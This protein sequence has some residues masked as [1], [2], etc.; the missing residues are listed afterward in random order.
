MIRIP[1]GEFG[2][3]IPIEFTSAPLLFAATSSAKDELALSLPPVM[4][5]TLGS[6]PD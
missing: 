3:P 1:A 5:L 6:L 2:F 4:S